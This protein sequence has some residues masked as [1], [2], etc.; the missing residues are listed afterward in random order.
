MDDTGTYTHLEGQMSIDVPGP[1]ARDTDPHTSH[2]AAHH[3]S[4]KTTIMRAM[5]AE[6]AR[7]QHGLTAEWVCGLTD[8][9]NGG[10]KRVS[11]LKRLGYVKPTGKTVTGS[12]GRQQQLLAITEEGR[13]ALR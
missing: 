8:H 10:W 5:L 7:Y 12:S 2:A 9:L 3:L 4:D 6:F 1:H 13:A 11:D